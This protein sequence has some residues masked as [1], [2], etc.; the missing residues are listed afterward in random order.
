M[1]LLATHTGGEDIIV[2]GEYLD[3]NG[4]IKRLN[5]SL[6]HGKYRGWTF[7]MRDFTKVWAVSKY[8][9]GGLINIQY[10][11][12]EDEIKYRDHPKVNAGDDQI[13]TNQKFVTLNGTKTIPPN[14]N[15]MKYRWSIVNSHIS[16]NT[17]SFDTS[18]VTFPTSEIKMSG[19]ATFR[20]YVADKIYGHLEDSD[21][22]V[23]TFNF[24]PLQQI[25]KG[26]H[27]ND[28][29]C[30]DDLKLIIKFTNNQPLCVT[31]KTVEKLIER[32]WENPENIQISEIQSSVTDVMITNV[33]KPQFKN[34]IIPE[35]I[36]V[37]LNVNSTVKWTNY[38]SCNQI[39]EHD[40]EYGASDKEHTK[41]FYGGDSDTITYF[42]KGVYH[43][44]LKQYPQFNGTVIVE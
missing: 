3:S 6:S 27:P 18:L 1:G 37:V 9:S 30:K 21:D 44:H 17:T 25:K 43:Y 13:I 42:E 32:G 8:S 22:V 29:I 12:P 14:S 15:D 39:V 33:C 11:Q 38:G 36:R 40:I 34:K 31:S 41:R 19:S 24:S 2:R 7:D 16:L 10:F 20:L 28:V 26:V 35:T 4:D 23:I 5:E